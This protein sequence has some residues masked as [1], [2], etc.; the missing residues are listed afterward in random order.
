[1]VNKH[2]V[3]EA[4]GAYFSLLKPESFSNIYQVSK[5]SHKNQDEVGVGLQEQ[6][7]YW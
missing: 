1:M 6:I 4:T 2:S 3:C 7:F 5:H